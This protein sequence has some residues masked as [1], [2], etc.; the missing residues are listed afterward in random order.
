MLQ[1]IGLD[2]SLLKVSM[3]V[4]DPDCG[5][6]AVAVELDIVLEDRRESLVWLNTVKS[7]VNLLRDNT[8]EFEIKDV[9]L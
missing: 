8:V 5:D 7:A 3:A 4:I 9:S 1:P 6:T 2:I